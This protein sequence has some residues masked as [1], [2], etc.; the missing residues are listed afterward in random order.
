MGLQELNE[1]VNRADFDGSGQFRTQ[2]DP[3]GDSGSEGGAAAAGVPF[4]AAA[5]NE[6]QRPVRDGF[7]RSMRKFVS[8][9]PVGV[10]VGIVAFLVA[11]AVLNFVYFRSALFSE[12]RVKTEITGPT[13]VASAESV[14]YT[15]H[16]SNDN[17]LSV[18]DFQVAVSVPQEFRPDALPGMTVSGNTLTFPI[19]EAKGGA[20]GDL[21]FSGKFYGSRGLLTYFQT[22][23]RFTPAGLSG[24]YETSARF[25][26]T[27]VSSPISI[28]MVSPREASSGNQADYVVSYR[29]EGDIAIQNL[30]VKLTYPDGFG[31]DQAVPKPSE[32]NASWRIGALAPG[33]GGEVRVSGILRGDENQAK[34]VIAEIGSVQGDGTFLA[35]DR[36]EQQTRI[37]ASPLSITQTV[38]G[39][40]EYAA[41]PGERLNYKID[42]ANRGNIGL[43]DV[44]ITMEVN[45]NL[46][47]VTQLSFGTG[48]GS[49]DVQRGVITWRASDIPGLSR[50]EP[51]QGGSVVF[52]VP[53]RKDIDSGKG[54]VVRS[55]AKIDSPDVPFSSGSSKVVASDAIDVRIGAGAAIEA[56]VYYADAVLPGSGPIPPRVGQETS[57]ALHLRVTNLLNDLSGVRVTATIPNGV[58]Y[59]GVKSPDSETVTYNERTGQLVWDIGTMIGG[60]K[61]VREL[62]LRM[63]LV[64]GPNL[65]NMQPAILQDAVLEGTDSFTKKSVSIRTGFRTTKT[66]EGAGSQSGEDTVAP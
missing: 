5:W 51:H 10:S 34:T 63:S 26:T 17:I 61:S 39:R 1:Q 56:S 46:L 52:S 49:Y 3:K 29:N 16:W 66:V 11:V 54:L 64:P 27:I 53:V 59:A 30:T 9:H 48:G 35:Y 19:G 8:R 22:S 42:Y 25:G 65:V 28:E 2:Y 50:L 24:A 21:R 23:A 40:Q 43:R 32:G 31:F 20:T 14:T 60:G 36:K 18:R 38:N 33:S 37:V 58:R 55:V 57:Y 13:D 44:I 47:D 62:I 7:R 15:I 4:G 6:M 41:T 12:D 45:A